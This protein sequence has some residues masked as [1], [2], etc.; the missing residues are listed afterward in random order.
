MEMCYW[1]DPAWMEK[2]EVHIFKWGKYP[3]SGFG[4]IPAYKGSKIQ[5]MTDLLVLCVQVLPKC[6]EPHS[7][8]WEQ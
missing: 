6:W 1:W 8:A 4:D 5:K 7:S 2:A 3:K